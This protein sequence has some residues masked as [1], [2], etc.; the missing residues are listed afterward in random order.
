[1]SSDK[2][3]TLID[4][5]AKHKGKIQVPLFPGF[6]QPNGYLLPD[7]ACHGLFYYY[8]CAQRVYEQNVEV[9]RVIYEGDLDPVLKFRDLFTSLSALYGVSANKMSKYWDVVDKQCDLMGF[10]RLPDE[11]QYRFDSKIILLH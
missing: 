1:M 2:E 9:E 3:S 5:L 4:A 11:E 7:R 10:P 6:M 8:L